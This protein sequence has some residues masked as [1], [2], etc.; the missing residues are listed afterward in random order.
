MKLAKVCITL[1]LEELVDLGGE[2]VDHGAGDLGLYL[3][4]GPLHH[5]LL[6]PRAPGGELEQ[7]VRPLLVTSHAPETVL[8]HYIN[9]YLE[10]VR[11][12]MNLL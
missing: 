3:L 2:L 4:L 10:G 5:Q 6:V 11:K 8:T 9:I 12:S 7:E 1:Y